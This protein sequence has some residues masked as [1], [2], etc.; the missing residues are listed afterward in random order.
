MPAPA[1]KVETKHNGIN[2]ST[3]R[4]KTGKGWEDWFALLDGEGA[5]TLDHAAIARTLND[6]H[7]LGL[8]HSQ[9]V[10]VGY[11]RARGIR[12]KNQKCTGERSVSVSKTIDAGVDAVYALCAEEKRRV[13]WLGGTDAVVRKANE[14]KNVRLSWGD[15][16]SVELRLT[17]KASGKTQ[18]VADHEKLPDNQAVERMRA[19]WSGALERL[20]TAAEA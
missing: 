13:G 10:A 18:I 4:E 19:Y 16:T 14:N 8:W 9:M 12:E 5:G 3:L 6:R 7:G 11:E 1:G 15:G 20:K 2:D 17:P